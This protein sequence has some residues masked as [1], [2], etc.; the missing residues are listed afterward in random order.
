MVYQQSENPF[1][2][3]GSIPNMIQ[4]KR[5]LKTLT[6]GFQLDRPNDEIGIPGNLR[7]KPRG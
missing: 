4:R 1:E 6:P 7:I 2:L 5:S 3:R